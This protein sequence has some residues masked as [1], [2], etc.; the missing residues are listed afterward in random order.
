MISNSEINNIENSNLSF[1][2]LYNISKLKDSYSV[3]NSVSNSV[4][5]DIEHVEPPIPRKA[6]LPINLLKYKALSSMKDAVK[7][8][9]NERKLRKYDEEWEKQLKEYEIKKDI[10]DRATA[11]HVNA[12]GEKITKN[13]Y[14]QFI[15]QQAKHVITK[16]F[17]VKE[18]INSDKSMK[19]RYDSLFNGFSN[20]ISNL[21]YETNTTIEQLSSLITNEPLTEA[22]LHELVSKLKVYMEIKYTHNLFEGNYTGVRMSPVEQKER[23]DEL[24]G[25]MSNIITQKREDETEVEHIDFIKN[26]LRFWTGLTYYDKTKTYKICYK[27]G[28]GININNLPHSH[29]CMYT[30]DIFGFRA[31]DSHEERE[32]FIYNKFKLA[33]GEQEMELH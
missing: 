24:K 29:T 15:L 2:I 19:K 21:L 32:N 7:N 3:S 17:L 33:V 31:E 25:Y 16:N 23:G 11:T 14:I 26:L 5:N 4:N 18:E 9:S 27:Y 13:N 10:Y 28:V 6:Q 12:N 20:K 8:S 22:I 1:N 30:I